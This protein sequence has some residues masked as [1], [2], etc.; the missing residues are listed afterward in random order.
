VWDT[1][2]RRERAL[3]ETKLCVASSLWRAGAKALPSLNS[4]SQTA[5]RSWMSDT[6]PP[7]DPLLL[8]TRRTVAG[9]LEA[10]GAGG[11]QIG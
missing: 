10:L 8:V 1:I 5:Q 3:S 11:V 4:T 6:L 9:A 2:P 7:Q